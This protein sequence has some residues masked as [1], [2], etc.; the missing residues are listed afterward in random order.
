MITKI[1]PTAYEKNRG[2][3]FYDLVVNDTLRAK[4]RKSNNGGNP[5]WAHATIY[6]C[7]LESN[8]F[9]SFNSTSLTILLT[10]LQS[11]SV[12]TTCV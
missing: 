6:Y 2:K 1:L 5:N 8:I 11:L 3:H 7:L 4:W 12:F 9:I 10:I